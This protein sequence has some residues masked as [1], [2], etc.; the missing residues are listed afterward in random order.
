[1][2]TRH[3]LWPG[4]LIGRVTLV[5]AFAILVQFAAGSILVGAS[6]AHMQR[7]DLGRRIAEQLLVAERMVE[8]AEPQARTR[9]LAT[10]STH[11]LSL[12][13]VEPAPRPPPPG[14]IRRPGISHNR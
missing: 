13:L 2:I 9:L 1:M 11:H 7:Q 8:A 6:E 4:G 12:S 5:L 10:L 3:S 14:S